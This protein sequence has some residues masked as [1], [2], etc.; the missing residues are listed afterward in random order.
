MK[1][2]ELVKVCVKCGGT[3]FEKF[4]ILGKLDMT[5]LVCI[6]CQG[7]TYITLPD[8]DVNEYRKQFIKK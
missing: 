1:M 7:T 4:R 5:Q 8:A 6:N 3:E 2:S